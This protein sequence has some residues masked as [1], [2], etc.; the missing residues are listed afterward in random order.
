M[1][2]N[3]RKDR[4]EAR[5]YTVALSAALPYGLSSRRD[6]LRPRGPRPTSASPARG[7]RTRPSQGRATMVEASG[8]CAS[9]QEARNI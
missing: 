3:G 6:G 7:K 8:Y 9:A 5:I 1:S 2:T 4:H